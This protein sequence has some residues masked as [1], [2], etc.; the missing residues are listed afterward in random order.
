LGDPQFQ[1]TREEL[2]DLVDVAYGAVPGVLC[3]AVVI[4]RGRSKNKR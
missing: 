2:H 4:D 3:V 1:L